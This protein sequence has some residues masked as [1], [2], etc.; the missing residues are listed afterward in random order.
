[1]PRTKLA[2]CGGCA[3]HVRIGETECPFCGASTAALIAPPM[4]R[5]GTRIALAFGAALLGA[6]GSSSTTA[7]SPEPDTSDDVQIEPA[8]A[9]DPAP[10]DDDDDDDPGSPVEMYGGPS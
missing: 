3:R 8:P 10:S 4:G 5:A 6:C 7:P 9:A 1:M 2:P